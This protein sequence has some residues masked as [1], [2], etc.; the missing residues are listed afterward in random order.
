MFVAVGCRRRPA[1]ERAMSLRHRKAE[2]AELH[3]RLALDHAK[4]SVLRDR[5]SD[6]ATAY[7]RVL[8]CIERELAVVEAR[9]E[10][11]EANTAK[12]LEK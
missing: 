11:I 2:L 12:L 6:R 8:A 1:K 7:D 9:L 4:I 5:H 3:L 10:I